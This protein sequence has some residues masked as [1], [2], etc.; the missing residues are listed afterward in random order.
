MPTPKKTYCFTLNN[1]TQD[2]YTAI[3]RTAENEC[4]YAI[5]G[6]ETGESGT[7]HLQGYCIF[8]RAHRFDTIKSRYLPRCHIEVA[9]GDAGS[10]RRY[11]SKDGNFKEF[12]TIPSKQK[13]TGDRDAIARSFR[14]QLESGRN[15]LVRFVDEHPGAWYFSG[16]NL[17]RNHLQCQP[18]I[19]RPDVS[20]EWFHG[21]PGIGK[22]RAAHELLKE[23]F[24]K[25]PR[26]K[27]WSGYLLE[28]EVIIDDFGPNGI[29]INHLLRWLDRYKCFVETKG[30]IIPLYATKFIITS[31][32]TPGE[33]FQNLKWKHGPDT[34]Y[35]EDPQLPA[36][37]R[38][39]K[40][41]EFKYIQKP[42][43]RVISPGGA[44]STD[45]TAI[46][47]VQNKLTA[48]I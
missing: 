35:E 20:A 12:G 42:A 43:K 45:V 4:I 14:T 18:A 13:G 36:L 38:R 6:I 1:Y 29:G 41:K 9:A 32:F 7:P 31:N 28:K 23:A 46:L 3:C 15:G 19:E 17:L 25:E 26:T 33:C 10:N 27:W 8:K 44:R 47:I 40:I 37:L 39:I 16:H 48:L 34:V 30:G 21:P 5:V 2:E 22:S 11:C 24:V